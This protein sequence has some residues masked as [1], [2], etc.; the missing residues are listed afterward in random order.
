MLMRFFIG[1]SDMAKRLRWMIV[2][3][4]MIGKNGRGIITGLFFKIGKINTTSINARRRA[5]F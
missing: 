1:I 3:L 4:T 5:R 2:N